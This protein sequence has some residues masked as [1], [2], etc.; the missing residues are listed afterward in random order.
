MLG[1]PIRCCRL[2]KPCEAVADGRQV[3]ED[4]NTKCT[5]DIK[6]GDLLLKKAGDHLLDIPPAF[7]SHGA[8]KAFDIEVC[9]TLILR[10]V[11][12]ESLLIF[13]TSTS[14]ARD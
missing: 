9:S 4:M 7:H 5:G 6:V 10:P 3:G 8:K 1:I 11:C 12:H 13:E 2:Q 14:L